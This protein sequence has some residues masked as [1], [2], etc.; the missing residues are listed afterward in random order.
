MAGRFRS[1]SGLLISMQMLCLLLLAACDTISP[2]PLPAPTPR[3]SAI[4]V[5]PPAPA[6]PTL[7]EDSSSTPGPD[8]GDPLT[9]LTPAPESTAIPTPAGIDVE[10]QVALYAQVAKAL[11]KGETATYVY[12][13]PYIAQGERLDDPN[14][15]QPLPQR[16]ISALQ[17]S[18][19]SHKY[20]VTSFSQ[21]VGA[22]EDGGK[23]ENGGV[24]L[25]LGAIAADPTNP[26]ALSIRA[27]IYR[28]AGSAEGDSY[29]FVRD[30]S[31]WKL[32]GVTQEWNDN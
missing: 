25:T 16:L 20:S 15:D 27:S 12:I 8:G 13:S 29:H 19:G 2:T 30:G 5:T 21:A 22:L 23:V 1:A 11:L 7:T 3:S 10:A 4:T 17:S 18:D 24:F 14:E 31:A 26:D 9:D 32:T 28:K 6:G